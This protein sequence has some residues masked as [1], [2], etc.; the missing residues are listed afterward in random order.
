MNEAAPDRFAEPLAFELSDEEARIAAARAGFRNALRRR[1]SLRHVAPLAAFVLLMAFVAILALTG[2]LPRRLAEGLLIVA[3]IIFMI[4]RMA[5]HWRLRRAQSGGNA[6]LVAQFTGLTKVTP[7]ASGLSLEKASGARRFDYCA[8]S[9]AELTGAL[10]Y[11]WCDDAPAVI[12]A[13]AF[14]S[15]RDAEQFVVM[16]RAGIRRNGAERP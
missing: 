7:D 12:P 3:A 4:S 15:E 10:I 1:F 9:E 11:L 5:A 6:D 16:L 14:A 13:R 2:L 8:C